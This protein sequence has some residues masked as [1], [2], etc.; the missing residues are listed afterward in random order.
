MQKCKQFS[1][2]TMFSN[3]YENYTSDFPNINIW[4]S[5]TVFKVAHSKKLIV[6]P[7]PHIDAFCRLCSRQLST[8]SHRLSIQLWKFSMF[9]QNTFKVV[10]CKIVVWWKELTLTSKRSV[11]NWWRIK[12]YFWLWG[13]FLHITNLQ[14]TTSKTFCKNVEIEQFKILWQKEKLLIFSN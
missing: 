12:S 9:W 8:I 7:F 14:Q 6:N 3:L 13:P 5:I 1:S 4:F 2:P 11:L 10:C